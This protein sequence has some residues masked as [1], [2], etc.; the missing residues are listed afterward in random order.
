MQ[1]IE[2]FGYHCELH[3]IITRDGYILNYQ[4]VPQQNRPIAL[5]L[6][7]MASSSAEFVPFNRSLTYGLLEQ[8]YD[9]WLSNNRGVNWSN[10]HTSLD[11]KK[12]AKKFYDFSWHEM[13]I[14]DLPESIDYILN[15]TNQNDLQIVCYSQGCTTFFVMINE[16]PEYNNKVKLVSMIGPGSYLGHMKGFLKYLAPFTEALVQLAQRLRIYAVPFVNEIRQ[17]GTSVCSRNTNEASPL[18]CRLLIWGFQ[19]HYDISSPDDFAVVFMNLPMDFSI[20]QALHYSQLIYS[21]EFTKFDYGPK[22]N[23][24]E[25]GQ[26]NPPSYNLTKVTAPIAFYF[27]YDDRSVGLDVSICNYSRKR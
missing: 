25:Y 24:R 4:R 19:L 13:G 10:N 20:K 15:V 18:L 9:V 5:V 17:L 7:G 23:L 16:F 21:G 22:R 11:R 6:H 14:Y 8:G 2:G 1:F 3:T 12:D 27:G 26:I